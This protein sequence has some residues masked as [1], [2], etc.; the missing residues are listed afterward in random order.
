[1]G[2]PVTIGVLSATLDV[3]SFLSVALKVTFVRCKIH[4]HIMDSCHVAH[5][6]G[7]TW[8]TLPLNEDGSFYGNDPGD[9]AAGDR[10]VYIQWR[11]EGGGSNTPPPPEIPKFYKVEPDCKLSG[12]CLMFLF[13]HPN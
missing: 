12:K 5:A 4:A 6:Q 13:Q 11:T 10:F 3:K 7:I 9:G 1:V 2:V 8:S